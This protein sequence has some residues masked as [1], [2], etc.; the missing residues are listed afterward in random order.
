MTV[1]AQ[2]SWSVKT[3]AMVASLLASGVAIL[4]IVYLYT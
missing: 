4:M 3:K 1:Q 2:E